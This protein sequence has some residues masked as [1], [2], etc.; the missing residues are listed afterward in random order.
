MAYNWQVHSYI[1]TNILSL[2]AIATYSYIL[3]HNHFRF[4]HACFIHMQFQTTFVVD[5]Y[6]QELQQFK[7]DIYDCDNK[8]H[9]EDFSKQDYIGSA[10]FTLAEV[11]TS[12]KMLSKPLHKGIDL[13]I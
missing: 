8:K 2:V 4:M 9:I 6:F 13:T 7:V 10:R 12:G 3:L 11:L 5:Y 1:A